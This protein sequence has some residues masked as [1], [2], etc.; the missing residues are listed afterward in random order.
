MRWLTSP[1]PDRPV[2]RFQRPPGISA[3]RRARPSHRTE[4]LP[5]SAV[6]AFG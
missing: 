5:Q 3:W 6:R 4:Y 2:G 1:R